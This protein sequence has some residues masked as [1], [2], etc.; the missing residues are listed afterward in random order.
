MKKI[1]NIL[2]ALAMV[3]GFVSCQGGLLDTN[4]YDSVGSEQMWTNENLTDMGVMSIYETLRYSKVGVEIYFYD[5]F[6]FT[7]QDVM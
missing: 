5:E 1:N 7:G 6:G 2:V 3:A 4:P